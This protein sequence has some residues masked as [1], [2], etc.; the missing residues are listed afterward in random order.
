MK[1]ILFA[2]LLAT[3]SAHALPM[4]QGDT[5]PIV[6]EAAHFLGGNPTG[7]RSNWCARFVS[8]I[9]QRE[10]RAPLPS[11]MAMSALHYGPR[12]QSPKPG[13]L[14]VMRHHVGFYEGRDHRGVHM[15]SGNWSHRVKRTIISLGEVVAFVEVR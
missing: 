10:G 2:F 7:M 14:I 8:F 13:D 4:T 1:R 5:T 9:L 3:S 6:A 12:T 11:D 15:L